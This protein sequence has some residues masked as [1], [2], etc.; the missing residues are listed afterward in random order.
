[1]QSIGHLQNKAIGNARFRVAAIGVV[2]VGTRDRG[3]R[4][5]KTVQNNILL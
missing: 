4:R 1:M 5:P 3:V 2:N